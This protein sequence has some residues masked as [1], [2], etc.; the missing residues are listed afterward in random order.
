MSSETVEIDE[1]QAQ[2][3]ALV[4]YMTS[5][6]EAVS[7]IKGAKEEVKLIVSLLADEGTVVEGLVKSLTTSGLPVNRIPLEPSAMPDE[8]G[9]VEEAHLT[10]EGSLIVSLLD[11]QVD[12]FD[13]SQEENRG[14]LVSAMVDIVP[15]L[16]SV[17]D[18]SLVLPELIIEEEAVEPETF[19]VPEE[20]AEEVTPP[21][22]EVEEEPVEVEEPTPE[23]VEESTLEELTE[24]EVEEP[25]IMEPTVEE[26]MVSV[27][28]IE[29]PAVE[30]FSLPEFDPEAQLSEAP[31]PTRARPE[32]LERPVKPP[33]ARDVQVRRLRR[34]VKR[35]RSSA[36]IEMEKVRRQRE[37]QIR[38]LR[39][40]NGMSIPYGEQQ[41]EGLLDKLKGLFSKLRS[42]K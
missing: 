1:T 21:V 30:E 38:R 37:A 13:L 23:E 36:Q 2:Q 11:G 4:D 41:G 31:E 35:Q 32:L 20:V 24:E 9:E 34:A 10:S 29:E 5:A 12:S 27:S 22:P 14:L 16:H 6:A 8:L 17:L 40:T 26:D 7:H 28:G 33:V 15:K 3:G 25:E 18:G 19:E 42:R 39:T